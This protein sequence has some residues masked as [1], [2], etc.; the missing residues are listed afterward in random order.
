[1]ATYGIFFD[2]S[3]LRNEL[4]VI[5]DQTNAN[6]FRNKDIQTILKT[7][8][9]N[10]SQD[11]FPESYKL[12]SLIA[13]I[14]ATTAS[15]ERS[16]SCLNRIKTSLRSTMSQGRLSNLALLSIET[17]LLI[18]LSDHLSWYEN[19]INKFAEEKERKIHLLFK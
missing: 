3:F 14:P 19:I 17:E 4:T 6:L 5:Y 8:V 10:D 18:K 2:R 9:E 16:F 15:V 7:I 12:F 11:G 1:M 13:T